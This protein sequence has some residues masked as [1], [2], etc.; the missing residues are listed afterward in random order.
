MQAK[1]RLIISYLLWPAIL[2]ACI[3]ATIYGFNTAH[4]MV[5]FNIT[6]FSLA[7]V[8]AYLEWKMPHE[9]QWRSNDGQMFADIAHTLLSKGVVQGLLAFAGVFGLAA[10]VTSVT[11]PGYGIWPRGWPM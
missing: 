11:E 5:A 6:Y 2:T 10:I 1:T 4:P 9:A 3:A 8:L 7:A